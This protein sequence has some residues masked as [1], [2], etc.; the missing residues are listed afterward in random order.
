MKEARALLPQGI[1]GEAFSIELSTF[2]VDK[3]TIPYLIDV[4]LTR[5]RLQITMITPA[6]LVIQSRRYFQTPDPSGCALVPRFLA[7]IVFLATWP[8]QHNGGVGG[9]QRLYKPTLDQ[10]RVRVGPGPLLG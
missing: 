4:I 7:N 6:G 9:R 3:C 2:F 8:L 10:V 1:A 5:I